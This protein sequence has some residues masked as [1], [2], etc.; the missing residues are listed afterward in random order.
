MTPLCVFHPPKKANFILANTYKHLWSDSEF[1]L[2]H[3]L[4]KFYP[5]SFFVASSQKITSDP[6]IVWSRNYSCFAPQKVTS[7]GDNCN[8]FL[9]SFSSSIILLY[10]KGFSLENLGA[11]K[12]DIQKHMHLFNTNCCSFPNKSLCGG[13]KVL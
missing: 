3:S 10:C 9:A 6:I 8:I 2:L 11:K 7:N 5:C 12:G 13:Q 1:Y 4:S